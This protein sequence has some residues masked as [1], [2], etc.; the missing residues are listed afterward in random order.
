MWTAANFTGVLLQYLNKYLSGTIFLNFY[1][2]G[3]AGIVGFAIGKVLNYIWKTK[4]SFIV[5]YVVT[6][7]GAFFIFMFEGEYITPYAFG[8]CECTGYPHESPEDKKYH[9]DN[10]IPWFTFLAKVGTNITY[11]AASYA[12]FSDPTIFP[13]LKRSTA[14]GICDLFAIGIT[15]FAPFVAELERPIPILVVIGIS[16]VG[17]GVSFTFQSRR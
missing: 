15:I 3:V 2:E 9:L 12:S 16:L 7:L 17:L 4:I 14:V 6:I 1:I 5:S 11:S 13:L 10:I 8:T